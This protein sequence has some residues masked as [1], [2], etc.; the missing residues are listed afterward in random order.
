MQLGVGSLGNGGGGEI[1][2]PHTCKQGFV[3]CK[4]GG[5]E[6][7]VAQQFAVEMRLCAAFSVTEDA[8]GAAGVIEHP[9]L[10]RKAISKMRHKKRQHIV[11]GFHNRKIDPLGGFLK[12]G[13]P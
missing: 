4:Q 13:E 7:A 3:L 9:R 10:F 8:I 11:A 2:L 6:P 5:V 12:A 1:L